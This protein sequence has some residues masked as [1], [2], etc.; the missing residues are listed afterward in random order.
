MVLE[1]T[2]KKD[3]WESVLQADGSEAWIEY[4]YK[5]PMKNYV[6]MIERAEEVWYPRIQCIRNLG[7]KL[8]FILLEKPTEDIPIKIH[9]DPTKIDWTFGVIPKKDRRKNN[10]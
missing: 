6:E 10:G 5:I 3:R 1:I 8:K 4:R 2:L 9:I 7:G